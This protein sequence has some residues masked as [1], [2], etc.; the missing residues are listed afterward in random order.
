MKAGII[1][2]EEVPFSS[3]EENVLFM[4][5]VLGESPPLV[6]SIASNKFGKDLFPRL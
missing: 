3:V 1:M 5:K 6:K 4:S 2:F